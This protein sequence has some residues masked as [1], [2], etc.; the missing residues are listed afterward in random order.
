MGLEA[1]NYYVVPSLS[2]Y[3]NF[4]AFLLNLYIEMSETCNYTVVLSLPHI[5]VNEP[6]GEGGI[7]SGTPLNLFEGGHRSGS[8]KMDIQ[9]TICTICTWLIIWH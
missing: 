1:G 9:L 4:W 5:G 3:Y 2:L 6:P 7:S 8:I